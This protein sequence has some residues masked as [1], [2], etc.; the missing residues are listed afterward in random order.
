MIGE[1]TIVDAVAVEQDAGHARVLAG[2][3]VGTRKRFQRSQGYIAEIA[4]RGSDQI[5]RRRQRSG[6]NADIE[7]AE[8]ARLAALAVVVVAH[9][10]PAIRLVSIGS[11]WARR[12]TSA[13]ARQFSRGS[14]PESAECLWMTRYSS[15]N[16]VLNSA[17][18][19]VHS[20][21]LGPQRHPSG[22]TRCA[23]QSR[24]KAVASM[25]I[26]IERS[27]LLKSLNH[28]HRVV[29]RRNTIPILS[30]V[31]LKAEGANLDMKATD[32]DLEVTE[33]TP[34]NVEQP[35]ATT[36]PAHL[37]YDIVRK[38]SDGSEVLLATNSD[39]SSMTVA[40]GAVEVL[41]AMP[42]GIRFPGSDGRQLQPQLP[43]ESLGPE[44]A[45]RPDA[46]RDFDGR[47]ALLS[48]RHLP[49]HDRKQGRPEAARRGDR[50]TPPCARRRRRPIRARKACR[51]SSFRARPSANCRSSSIAPMPSS[52]SRSPTP[53]SG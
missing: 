8:R 27:N 30:N 17:I 11:L 49:P 24:S 23:R 43:P 14:A 4:D 41:A 35:G 18:L 38:L 9:K 37:L 10:D 7:E 21:G 36:V 28:V 50:R 20:C 5:E 1:G 29:E 53:R 16:S 46:V 15:C 42:A 3:H 44:D 52:R 39:G 22:R 32:L 6:R 13:R 48:E 40:V 34:A 12:A 33:A 26:T 25:R 2:K 45:D 19:P 51:A 31:L 47:D